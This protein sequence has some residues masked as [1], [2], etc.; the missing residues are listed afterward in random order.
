MASIHVVHV[1]GN[2]KLASTNTFYC[3]GVPI[4]HAR[5]HSCGATQSFQQLRYGNFRKPGNQLSYASEVRRLHARRIPYEVDG[6]RAKNYSFS[7]LEM[8]VFKLA[9]QRARFTRNR[10][11]RGRPIF[12]PLEHR[13]AP[14]VSA[15]EVV[16][17][18]ISAYA[19]FALNWQDRTQSF[20]TGNNGSSPGLFAFNR[21]HLYRRLSRQDCEADGL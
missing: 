18:P 12:P 16:E 13:V 19:S 15:C 5:M 17:G 14:M 2:S 3:G 11:P 9:Y 21:F 1:S 7:V 10:L 4:E 20:E 8:R 6:I